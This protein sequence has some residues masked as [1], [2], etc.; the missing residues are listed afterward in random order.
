MND[1]I[2]CHDSWVVRITPSSSS[3]VVR[4]SPAYIHRS[5][6]RPGF[7]R[8]SVWVQDIDLIISMGVIES[9]FAELPQELDTGSLRVEGEVFEDL[10]PLPLDVQGA[11]RFSARSIE[12][13]YLLIQG[14]RAT[15]VL[16]GEARYVESFPGN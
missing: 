7:A 2:E 12:G 4:F 10:L 13:E 15:V 16:V 5:E 11:V 6:G 3:V 8:G 1:N 14:D 9:T